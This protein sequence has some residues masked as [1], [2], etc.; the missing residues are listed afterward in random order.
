MCACCRTGVGWWRGACARTS[1]TLGR[2]DE[3]SS[4]SS[5]ERGGQKQSREIAYYRISQQRYYL[6]LVRARRRKTRLRS[7]FRLKIECECEWHDWDQVEN[8]LQMCRRS[9]GQHKTRRDERQVPSQIRRNCSHRGRSPQVDAALCWSMAVC[10][11]IE[12]AAMALK[13]R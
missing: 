1:Q 8:G 4:K 2:S 5:R 11:E 6:D 13:R 7:P 9:D 10:R 12:S 3:Y